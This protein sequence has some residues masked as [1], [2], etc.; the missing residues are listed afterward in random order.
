MKNIRNSVYETNSSSTHS[1]SVSTDTSGILSTIIPDDD[2]VITLEGGEFGWGWEKF[3]DALTKAN[4]AA[5]Y[6][7][8]YA[9]VHKDHG[10]DLLD[11][12]K[13]VI[14]EH[15]GAKD[16]VFDLGLDSKTFKSHI[17]HQS[18]AFENDNFLVSYA[19]NADV[20]KNWIFNP[21]SWLFIGDDNSNHPPNF[22]DA[23]DTVYDFELTFT[24]IDSE[25]HH[26]AYLKKNYD[27]DDVKSMLR[28]VVSNH[29]HSQFLKQDEEG[30][31]FYHS[32]EM[33]AEFLAK[34]LDNDE[35]SLYANIITTHQD[36]WY[37]VNSFYK[38][39]NNKIVIF[40]T[41]Y[42]EVIDNSDTEYGSRCNVTVLKELEFNFI[43]KELN[44]N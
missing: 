25:V 41:D 39:N 30:E 26:V 44:K 37:N 7:S 31:D 43:I 16:I 22:F 4:Y 35:R 8:D 1:F 2:G 32:T 20:M 13:N 24:G 34:M 40:I 18:N 38:F 3:N 29:I 5:V 33:E 36:D 6:I 17:D 15:T 14:C 21:E 9:M 19:H 11:V 27:I 10:N 23:K 28:I 42:E 12:L